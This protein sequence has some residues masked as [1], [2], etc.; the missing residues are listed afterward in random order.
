MYNDIS[1]NAPYNGVATPHNRAAVHKHQFVVQQHHTVVQQHQT[2]ALLF[3]V[4]CSAKQWCCYALAPMHLWFI[5]LISYF[6]LYVQN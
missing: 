2:V 3:T 6:L 1:A 5:Y 4:W